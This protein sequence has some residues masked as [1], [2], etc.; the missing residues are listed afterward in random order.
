MI[1][2]QISQAGE[3]QLPEYTEDILSNL[4]IKKVFAIKD[5]EARIPLYKPENVSKFYNKILYL[6][7][8]YLR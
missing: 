1:M 7:L 6:S 2:S 8:E 3:D 5:W 4:I